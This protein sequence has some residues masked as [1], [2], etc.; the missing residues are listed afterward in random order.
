MTRYKATLSDPTILVLL[1]V[2]VSIKRPTQFNIF[3]TWLT[4]YEKKP[5]LT[6][7]ILVK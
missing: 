4:V 3:P 2:T 7:D 6:G 5:Q 1:A